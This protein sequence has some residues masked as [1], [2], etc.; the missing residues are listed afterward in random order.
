VGRPKKSPPVYETLEQRYRRGDKPALM[1]ELGAHL[2]FKDKNEPMPEWLRHGLLLACMASVQNEIDSWDEVLGSPV[3][4]S[5]N[6]HTNHRNLALSIRIFD[7]VEELLAAGHKKEPALKMAARELKIGTT[8]TKTLYY[9]NRVACAALRANEAG[10]NTR[11]EEILEE[12]KKTEFPVSGAKF[13]E[14]N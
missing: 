13:S 4:G 1:L 5:K 12:V 14:T 3:L 6:R 7:R 9:E 11:L 2:L 8:R 10:D